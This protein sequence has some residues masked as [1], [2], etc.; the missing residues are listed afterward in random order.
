VSNDHGTSADSAGGTPVEE[1]A[2]IL[3]TLAA[4]VRPLA[5]VLPGECEVVLHELAKLPDSIVAIA[6]D[7]SGRPV[8]GPATDLLLRAGAQGT[9]HTAVGYRSRHPDGRE[10]RSSTIIVRDSAGTAVAALCVNSDTRNW[11]LLADL[12]RS[13][14]PAEP[15]GTATGQAAESENL[16]RDVDDLATD[17]LARA[18]TSVDVP[19]EL[20]QKRHKV[21]VVA[22]LKDRGFFMLKESV[23]TAAQALGVTRFTVYNYLNELEKGTSTS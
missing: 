19:V 6:G 22:D 21:A 1:A 3:R 17:L 11:E 15:D 8:G 2:V 16:I 12:A 18:I 20:M 5:A 4:L 9:Y 13:M 10:L 7:L 14:L 23:E